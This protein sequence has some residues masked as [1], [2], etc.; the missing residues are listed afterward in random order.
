MSNLISLMGGL[1]S[2]RWTWEP[3]CFAKNVSVINSLLPKVR[4]LVWAMI[5]MFSYQLIFL[6]LY[7]SFLL[8][9]L[10][11]IFIMCLNWMLNLLLIRVLNPEFSLAYDCGQIPY[12]YLIFPLPFN[13]K[14]LVIRILISSVTGGI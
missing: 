10:V 6:R 2:F 9:C 3:V 1:Y 11:V 5:S 4:L 8:I 14:D 12:W 13:S 7:F